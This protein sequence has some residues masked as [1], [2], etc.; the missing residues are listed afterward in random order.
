MARKYKTY[1]GNTLQE[2]LVKMKMDLGGDAHLVEHRNIEDGGFLG[3]FRKRKVE[4]TGYIDVDDSDDLAG[5]QT[6]KPRDRDGIVSPI[7]AKALDIINSFNARDERATPKPASPPTPLAEETGEEKATHLTHPPSAKRGPLTY[8][9]FGQIKGGESEAGTVRDLPSHPAESKPSHPGEADRIRDME[10]NY[11]NLQDELR[12]IKQMMERMMS[13]KTETKLKSPIVPGRAGDIPVGAFQYGFQGELG[14]VYDLLIENDV[15]AT[16][17][18]RITRNLSR[19]LSEKDLES[20]STIRDKL[21]AN[22]EKLI[23]VCGPINPNERQKVV[24]LVGPTGVGKTTTIAKL[25]ANFY[26]SEKKRVG[27]ITVDTYRI[28]AVDQ[29]KTYGEIIGIPV[30]VAFTPQEFENMVN[31]MNDKDLVLIDTAGRNQKNDLQ[32]TELVNYLQRVQR[33]E[34]YLVLS[35]TTKY[36]DMLNILDNFKKVSFDRLIFT[37]LDET[38]TYGT[39]LN[40][41]DRVDQPLS[42]VTTGQNVPDDIEVADAAKLARN[43]LGNKTYKLW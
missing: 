18:S 2:A 19:E 42:Y 33:I 27:L 22:I 6:G 37:K 13:A 40:V 15:E 16:L 14:R 26:L 7:R 3:L 34:I 23:K 1:V 11:R 29:L 32:M 20:P 39:M 31:T 28:A 17:A 12:E 25:A 35:A 10:R 4:V 43:I 36:K 8:N 9:R 41:M 21:A 30:K 38:T 24:A 5:G